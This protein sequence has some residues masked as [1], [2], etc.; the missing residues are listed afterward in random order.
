MKKETEKIKIFIADDHQLVID[1]ICSLLM[2]EPE[3]EITGT[4]SKS[5]VM[6]MLE[7]MH[8]DILLTDVQ[9]PD[10]SGVELTRQI[11]KK[12]PHIYVLALSMYGDIDVIKQMID[13]G[14]S[15][16]ILKNT[17]KKELIEA[18]KKIAKGDNY[19]SP[20]ITREL[21]K[22]VKTKNEPPSHLTNREI[23]II[24][25]I[26]KDL[27]NKQIADQLFISER[28]IETHRKNIL[29]KT[30]T[31]SAVG[32]LKFAYENKII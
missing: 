11:R 21:M 18:L 24:R 5:A 27:G 29:R 26:A 20:E 3:F 22:A 31:Q 28:T 16:Y 9:M 6:T 10:V 13:S 1:G 19:F 4:S 8:V 25:L 32:L 7:K 15:G 17:G 14:I 30:N 23:E 12:H 2:N